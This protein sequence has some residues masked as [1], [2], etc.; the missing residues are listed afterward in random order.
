A[1]VA[2]VEFIDGVTLLL[3]GDISLVR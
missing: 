2:E 3:K 1:Y